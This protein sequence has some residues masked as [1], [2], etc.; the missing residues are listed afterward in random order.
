MPVLVIDCAFALVVATAGLSLGWWLR[1]RSP[2]SQNTVSSD[3]TRH[4]REVLLR[5]REL[6]TSVAADVDQHSNRVQEI[7]EELTGHEVQETEEVLGA[8]SRL[9]RANAEMQEQLGTAED[10]LTEQKQL[11]ESHATEART[12]GLTGLLNRRALDDEMARRH[13]E[14]RR[15]GRPFS[16]VILDVD[17]FKKFNDVYGHQAGDEVLRSLGD[18][19]RENARGA[20]LV[21]RY[22]GEEFAVVLPNTSV[23]EALATADR[24][25][26]TI[27]SMIIHFRNT[28]LHVTAS[29]GVAEMQ[30]GCGTATLIERADDALYSSKDAERNCVHWHDGKNIHAVKP[31]GSL[32]ETQDVPEEEEPTAGALPLEDDPPPQPEPPQPPSAAPDET[33]DTEGEE[34]A[35]TSSVPANP[36]KEDRGKVCG[37]TAF[38]LAVGRRLAERSRG[39]ASIS[40]VLIRIDDYANIVATHGQPVGDTALKATTQFLIAALRDMDLVAYYDTATFAL[41]LPGTKFEDVIGITERLRTAISRCFLNTRQGTINFTVSAGA[42][43]AAPGNDVMLSDDTVKLLKRT[44]ESLDAAVQS[45]GN[46]A[47]FHNGQWSEILDAALERIDNGAAG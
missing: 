7:N 38:L 5:L 25:R 2:V 34:G 29:F 15:E 17:H 32:E 30:R 9:V 11:I 1:S 18:V 22:G 4:A 19:L 3:E 41:L 6:V 31:E 36:A 12:D 26:R 33:V 28:K 43:Q 10:R 45:G 39:G 13:A 37:R 35:S 16:L 8:V 21:A 42:A 14:F 20:D 40:V 44:E 24:M 47:Y 23:D 46:C 27:D